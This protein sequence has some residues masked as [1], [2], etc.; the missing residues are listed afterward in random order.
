WGRC[1]AACRSG[2]PA[3]SA[4]VGS[5]RSSRPASTWRRSRSCS[6]SSG[7]SRRSRSGR[8]DDECAD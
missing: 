7:P 5:P 2:R 4:S 1:P 6:S 3:R 8:S